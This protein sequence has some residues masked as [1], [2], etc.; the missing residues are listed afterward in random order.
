MKNVLLSICLL[1]AFI[2]KAQIFAPPGAVWKYSILEQW[3]QDSY[4]TSI[5]Y[6]GDTIINDITA[7]KISTPYVLGYKN[8]YYF[9]STDNA[10]YCYSYKAQKFTKLF[11]YSLNIGDSLF[12]NT[13]GSNESCGS[14]SSGAYYKV[15]GKGVDTINNK[16][17]RWLDYQIATCNDCVEHMYGKYYEKLGRENDF[18]VPEYG[19]AI[20][21]GYITGRCQYKDSTAV[22]GVCETSINEIPTEK[23]SLY[24]NPITNGTL[25][26][27]SKATVKRIELIDML[28]QSV[29]TVAPIGNT[30]NIGAVAQGMYVVRVLFT[31]GKIGY[32]RVVVE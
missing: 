1:L 32:K 5:V 10:I 22:I 24:P 8:Q 12:I 13:I 25:T 26:I 20:Y 29:L 21:T 7:Q 9:Y 19:C 27:Q 28:G 16:P 15:I 30:L 23:F 17:Y 11:D 4:V 14:D 18:I 31:D 3:S 6:V 2:A